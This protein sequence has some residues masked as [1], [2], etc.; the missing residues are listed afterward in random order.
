MKQMQFKVTA[1]RREDGAVLFEEQ[2]HGTNVSEPSILTS[3]RQYAVA[4]GLISPAEAALAIWA[5]EFQ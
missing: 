1:C 4:S 3:T 5:V 2:G